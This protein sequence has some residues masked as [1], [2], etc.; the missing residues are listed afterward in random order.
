[1]KT[2]PVLPLVVTLL[3]GALAL[4]SVFPVMMSPMLFDSG[5][6]AWAW[7]IFSA[8]LAFPILCVC[9][10]VASWVVWIGQRNAA[11]R[12]RWL[13][14]AAA[15]LPLVPVAVLALVVGWDAV[16]PAGLRRG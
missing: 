15:C 14:V 3:W 9:S 8:I 2:R 7:G 4:A 11:A 5:E 6:S 16:A 10:I 1:V 13:P 12:K